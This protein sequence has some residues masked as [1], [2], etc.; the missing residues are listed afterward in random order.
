MFLTCKEARR[1]VRRFRKGDRPRPVVH[2]IFRASAHV[3]N[4]GC[5][6][7][8]AVVVEMERAPQPTPDVLSF[9]AHRAPTVST[10]R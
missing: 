1:I 7:C 10:A 8:S 2:L 5:E 3:D 9:P 4:C 6:F